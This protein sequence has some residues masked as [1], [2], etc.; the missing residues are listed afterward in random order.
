MTW[1]PTIELTVHVLAR[2][3]DAWLHATFSARTSAHGC[4]EE[5]GEFHDVSGQLIA[6]SRQLGLL[7]R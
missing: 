6:T 1:T 4:F 5:D 3:S 7:G 2:P